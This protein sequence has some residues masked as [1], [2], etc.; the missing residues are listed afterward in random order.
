MYDFV[1]YY[2]GYASAKY[3]F[4]FVR[5]ASAHRVKFVCIYFVFGVKIE[6]AKS[7]KLYSEAIAGVYTHKLDKLLS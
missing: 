4:A 7:V 2:V 5:R 1:F 3:F 6:Y